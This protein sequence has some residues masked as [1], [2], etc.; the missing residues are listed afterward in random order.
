MSS[1]AKISD[2]FGDKEVKH[3]K[4]QCCYECGKVHV[5]YLKARF[6]SEIILSVTGCNNKWLA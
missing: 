4:I 6:L 1:V 3:L 5:G 2:D